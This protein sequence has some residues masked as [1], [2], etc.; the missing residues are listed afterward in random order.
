MTNEIN[1]LLSGDKSRNV[2]ANG[3]YTKGGAAIYC[4]WHNSVLFDAADK[5]EFILSFVH[6]IT[7]RKQA[8]EALRISEDRYRTLVEQAA[9]AIWAVDQRGN[10]LLVNSRACDLLGYTREEFQHL[11]LINLLI[12]EDQISNPIPW[13][14]IRAGK[15]VTRERWL[16]R[17]DGS[18][19]PVE[20]AAKMLTNG[21][22]QTIIRDVTERKQAEKTLYEAHQRL[23]FHVENS[24][25]VVIEWDSGLR[26]QGWSP[27]AEK[28]FG[29]KA[30]EVVG[31]HPSEWRFVHGE[32]TPRV[33]EELDLLINGGG[34]PAGYGNRNYTKDG[35]VVHCEWYNSALRDATGRLTSLLSLVLNVTERKRAEEAL[36][37]SQA[38]LETAQAIT[39]L[40]SWELDLATERTFWSTEMFHL[41]R[42][43]LALGSPS[44]HEFFALVH[45]EDRQRAIESY[46]HILQGGELYSVEYRTDPERGP[47]RVI[48]TVLHYEN[49]AQG[50]LARIVGT[51]LDITERKRAE[52]QILRSLEQLH[53]LT[54]RL[55]VIREEER[56]R[57]AREIHDELGQ[58][59]TGLKMDL[60]WLN[61]RVVN[62][63]DGALREL[64]L[65]KTRTMAQLTDTIIHTVRRIA[66]DLRPGVLDNLGLLAALEW[67][68]QDFQKRTDIACHLK[69]SL[70]EVALDPEGTTAVFRIFQETLTNVAR[71]A[72]ATAVDVKVSEDAGNLVLEVHDNGR[73]ITESEIT[74]GTSL[75]LLGIRERV[76]LVGGEVTVKGTP[77]AGTSV[78]VQVPL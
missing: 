71:H 57:I 9:D 73:G 53:A 50:K 59:L 7:E 13:D 47:L 4:E 72:H 12:P 63:N 78:I 21:S 31:K 66:T 52:E 51:A 43:D 24:P 27:R 11:N 8:E 39:H 17:K 20:T 2:I 14:E 15:R 68:A 32:D 42:R 49:D 77:G 76:L 19:M 74:A 29:W 10:F 23:K 64:L 28:L 54:A 40:G 30:E 3:N 33:S 61:K 65:S 46:T 55:Q 69:T 48:R 75:G 1:R 60:A 5:P 6:D 18:L 37:Q 34:R 41:H 22:I 36:R 70:E 35:A 67:Q 26:V 16:R 25:L 45:P 38:N 58:T 56:T 62:T 44:V